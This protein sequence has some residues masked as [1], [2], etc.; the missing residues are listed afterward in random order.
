MST[1][2]ERA[3]DIKVGVFVTLGMVTLAICI[4]LIGQERRLFDRVVYLRALFPNVAGLKVGAPVRLAGVDVGIVSAIEFPEVDPAAELRLV[5]LVD[6][7]TLGPESDLKLDTTEP[8]HVPMNVALVG[9]DPNDRLELRVRISGEDQFG[10][11]Q[12][13]EDLRVRVQGG[14]SVVTGTRFFRRITRVEVVS[15]QG[16]EPGTSISLGVGR[17]KKITVVMRISADVLD[18]IRH[19]SEA[20]VDSMGLLG[21]KTIDISLGSQNFPPHKDGDVIRSA[22]SID[23][24]AALADA[25]RI[26][27]NVVVSTDELRKLMAGFAA[28]GGEEALV[29]AVRSIQDIADEIRTGQGLLH[30]IV[31]DDKSGQQYKD[32]VADVAASAKKLDRGL[33]QVDEIL[34]EVREG[35]GL[36]HAV[37]YGKEGEKT[38]AQAREAL[39]EAEQILEDVRTKQGIL[40]NLI[41]NE[42]RG[43]FVTNLNAASDEVKQAAEDARQVVADIRSIVDEVKEGK[44]TVGALLKDPTVYEDLKILLGNAR[45]SDAVK[46]LVRYSLSQEDKRAETPAQK[47]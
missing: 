4:F 3:R 16:N 31:F 21:D 35:E 38:I 45:R 10:Q 29:A 20:R 28:A 6:A 40:H 27:E 1:E 42:D 15:I 46:A 2:R 11:E 18:R 34:A 36:L 47:P 8:F 9:V 23:M 24:N 12:I 26:L 33:A 13:T 22:S 7:S 25:Q 30:Q 37:I 41:Y 39:A 19:D 5:P 17:L 14:R 43:E 32:I 44:G